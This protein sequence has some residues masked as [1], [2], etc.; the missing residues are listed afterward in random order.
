MSSTSEDLKVHR[1]VARQIIAN[2]RWHPVMMEDFG[3]RPEATVGACHA[4][5]AKCQLM[6][7]IV[8]FRQGWVPTVE[9]GGNGKDS[10]TALELDYA[11]KHDIPVLVMLASDDTWPGKYY[12]DQPERLAW[13]KQFRSNLNLPAEFFGYE[14][15]GGADEKRLP[16]FREQTR[17][18]LLSHHERLLAERAAAAAPGRGDPFSSAYFSNARDCLLEGGCIPFVGAGVFGDGPL[19]A[20]ALAAMLAADLG[21][22]DSDNAGCL[23]SVA[24]YRER[25]ARSRDLFL[26]RLNKVITEQS[27]A[28][29]VPAVLRLLLGLDRRPPLVVATTHDQMIEASLAQAGTQ[30]FAVVTHVIRS[31]DAK[32]DGQILVLRPEGPPAFSLAD[33]VEIKPDELAIYRPLGSP[34]LHARLDPALEIDTVV[35]TETDHLTFLGRLENQHMQVPTCFTKHLKRKPLLFLGYGLDVWQYRLVLHVFQSMGGRSPGANAIAVRQPA[36]DLEALAWQRLGTDIVPLDA[37]E[38]AR[39]AIAPATPV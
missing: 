4:E 16:A 35:I 9:Q 33:K 2:V 15:P 8:A 38:F 20:R 22:I 26:N 23:A 31:A 3:A 14:D 27:K 1:A 39:R 19:S 37:N 25:L 28:A 30:R 11:R 6:L 10:V 36:S 21:S 32:Y 12:D 13:I 24:E 7:L 17:K 34:L 29:E 5:L 18:V